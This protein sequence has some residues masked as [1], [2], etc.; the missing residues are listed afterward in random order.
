LIKILKQTNANK[1]KQSARASGQQSDS[2]QWNAPRENR[3]A[4]QHEQATEGH[5]VFAAEEKVITNTQNT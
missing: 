2:E 5:D 4:G 1:F 3:D